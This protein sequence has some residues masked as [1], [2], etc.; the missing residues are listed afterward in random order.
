MRSIFIS[1]GCLIAFFIISGQTLLQAA[2]SVSYYNNLITFH[3]D[4]D[5][6]VGTFANG[7][8][9]VHNN[10]ESV[11]I[12]SISPASQNTDSRIINGTMLNPPNST[13]QGYDSSLRD[14]SY[15]NSLNVDPGNT[16]ISLVVPAG[17]SVVKSISMASDEGRPII[18]DAAI[19][20]VLA[21]EPPSGSFRP[22]YTGADKQIIATENDLNYSRLGNYD[23]LGG[24]PDIT[25]VAANYER[26]WLEHC[27]EWVQRDIHPQNNMPT[28]GRDIARGSATGLIL[29]Q[30]NYTDSEKRVLLIRLVQYGIDIYGIARTGGEWYNNGGHNLGRKLPLLLAARVL[31]NQDILAYGDKEQHFIF[32]DDQQHFYVSQV[33]VDISHSTSW[34][35]DSRA[36]P[37]PYTSEDIGIAEWGI[38]HADR[39][40]ADN[41]NWG[42]TYR[43]VNGPAQTMHVL[44]AQLMDL[45]NLWNWPPLFD[46]ADRY[47][48]KENTS[49]SFPDY[50]VALWETYRDSLASDKV[51]L[52]FIPLLL[53][54]DD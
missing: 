39:P 54:Q 43:G 3:F 23:R 11:V 5:Y 22:P 52:P 41:N 14:M 12:N 42:A 40:T 46:Y 18:S 20:T 30:L 27:T 38:R 45:K 10:G 8:Y 53:M 31:D 26:V 6:A 50:F 2:T 44:A 47:Y 16:G 13:T 1:C 7:D 19:L 48:S 35:P 24:E 28:Y 36:D 15:N 25:D 34:D 32:Q 51:T 4:G 29:L 9:W 21:S 37:I 33:E 49:N 17:T